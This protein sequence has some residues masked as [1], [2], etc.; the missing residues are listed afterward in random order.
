MGD[1]FVAGMRVGVGRGF[2][3]GVRDRGDEDSQRGVGDGGV[4][5][6]R[7]GEGREAVDKLCEGVG[8]QARCEGRD[9]NR[10]SIITVIMRSSPTT[11]A[12]DSALPRSGLPAS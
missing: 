8:G 1:D 4:Y 6:L 9:T 2:G 10:V 12:P 7:G 5:R 3:V 11:S